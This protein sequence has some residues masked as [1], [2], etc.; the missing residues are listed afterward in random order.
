M[1]ARLPFCGTLDRVQARLVITGAMLVVLT[2]ACSSEG[3]PATQAPPSR[4]SESAQ[5][6]GAST[7]VQP[8]SRTSDPAPTCNPFRRRVSDAGSGFVVELNIMSGNPN[9]AWRLTTAEG[10]ELRRLLRS[11]RERINVDPPDDLGGMG[12]TTD[13]P[14]AAFVTRIGLPTQFWVEGVSEVSTFLAGTLPCDD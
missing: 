6:D 4:P 3:E 13:G 1:L 12:V 9:P 11:E 2:V 8:E 7:T 14:D 5:T 10:A